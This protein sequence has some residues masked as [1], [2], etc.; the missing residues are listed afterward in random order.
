MDYYQNVDV[1][2]VKKMGSKMG[3]DVDE[4]IRTN[5]GVGPGSCDYNECIT[6]AYL[7]E[8]FVQNDEVDPSNDR[9]IPKDA[10]KLYRE[11]SL[12]EL[13]DNSWRGVKQDGGSR[14]KKHFAEHGVVQLG[15]GLCG[16]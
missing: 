3:F 8:L 11:L 16:Q 6:Q 12:I 7:N 4:L 5:F 15:H 1:G 2:Q 14:D 13:R 10:R 9:R